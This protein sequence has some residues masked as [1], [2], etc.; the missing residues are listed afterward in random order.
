VKLTTDLLLVLRLKNAWSYTSTPPVG[1]H[2]VVL[3]E[4]Q[5]QIDLYLSVRVTENRSRLRPHG[6]SGRFLST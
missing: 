3:S 5:G 1:L 2:G 4:A 6:H